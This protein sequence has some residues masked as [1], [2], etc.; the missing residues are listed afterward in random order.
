MDG[1]RNELWS[2][3]RLPLSRSTMDMP[4]SRAN[5]RTLKDLHTMQITK[6]PK[7]RDDRNTTN[8]VT[9]GRRS[10]GP[11]NDKNH[12]DSIILNPYELQEQNVC[13]GSQ[14]HHLER[15]HSHTTPQT[16]WLEESSRIRLHSLQ[17]LLKLVIL[18]FID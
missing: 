15:D 1:G 11:N 8:P 5:E 12:H 3:P 18:T 6:S 14:E 4:L 2:I 13:K 7:N 9:H 16:V 10:A 17:H